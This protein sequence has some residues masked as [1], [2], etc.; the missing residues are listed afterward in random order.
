MKTI[1]G[2]IQKDKETHEKARQ[3]LIKGVEILGNISS[4]ISSA[5]ATYPPAVLAFGGLCAAVQYVFT[6]KSLKYVRQL[7]VSSQA[8]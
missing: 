3:N 8:F 1:I 7:S 4:T 6:S 2:S 5:L